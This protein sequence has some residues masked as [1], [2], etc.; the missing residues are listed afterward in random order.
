MLDISTIGNAN[1]FAAQL[2]LIIPLFWFCVANKSAPKILRILMLPAIPYGMFSA[3]RTG[4]RGA[5][6][7]MLFMYIAIIFRAQGMNRIFAALAL[8]VCG[9]VVFAAIPNEVGGRLLSV[10]DDKQ[11]TE[12]ARASAFGRKYL[13]YRSIDLTVAHPVFGVGPGEFA[14]V[15][16]GTA[17]AS[18][19]RGA[20]MQSHNSYTQISSEAGIPAAFLLIGVLVKCLIVTIKVGREARAYQHRELALLAGCW[21]ISLVGFCTCAFFLSLAFRIYFPAIAGLTIAL[22]RSASDEFEK[23]ATAK[24]A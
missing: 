19:N 10:F 6:I 21:L 16:G 11:E 4:S 15:E 8:P 13:F 14:N 18:G 22:H 5:L 7:G 12:E 2:I 9:I 20:W 1:D 23:I 24:A 3:L 17:T